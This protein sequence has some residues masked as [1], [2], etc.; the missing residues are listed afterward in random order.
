[1][2]FAD[3]TALIPPPPSAPCI[4][5]W[6]ISIAGDGYCRHCQAK[7][8]FPAQMYEFMDSQKYGIKLFDIRSA[9]NV[10]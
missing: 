1:M 5:H 9:H 3:V 10:Y 2:T 7:R 4:H 6:I 8:Q